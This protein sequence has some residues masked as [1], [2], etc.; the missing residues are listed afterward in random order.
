MYLIKASVTIIRTK[1]YERHTNYFGIIHDW[2]IK[3]AVR[4]KAFVSYPYARNYRSRTRLR[5]LGTTKKNP[6]RKF[7][8]RWPEEFH[9]LKGKYLRVFVRQSYAKKWGGFYLGV[10]KFYT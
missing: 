2:L 8:V 9:F 5:T 7:D 4:K 1:G 3:E 10:V 6:Y